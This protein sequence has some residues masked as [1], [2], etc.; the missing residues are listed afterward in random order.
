VRKDMKDLLL[1]T[2]RHGGY[3]K[4]ASSRRARIKSADPDSLP[5]RLSSSRRRVGDK[6]QGDRLNPLRR[7]LK[8]NC[9]RLWADVYA[10]ICEFAD[11]RTIR[12]YHLRQH[13]WNYVVPNN[14]GVGHNSRYGPFFVDRDGTLQEKREQTAAERAAEQAYYRKRYKWKEPPSKRA[15]PRIAVDADHWYEKVE[16][17]WFAFETKHYTFKNSYE[18]LVEE[19]GEIKIVRI[20][21]PEYTRD[22]TTKRQV[23]GKT[24]KE[25]DKRLVA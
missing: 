20:P 15:N 18:D 22:V 16:G 24:Q 10:E 2:G 19:N 6:S 14:F 11:S 25:L 7:F 1:D 21:L 9:G 17:F 5:T 3:G 13:V 12:G 8:A 23:N 4:T